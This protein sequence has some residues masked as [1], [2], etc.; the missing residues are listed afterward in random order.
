MHIE[1]GQFSLQKIIDR[2]SKISNGPFGCIAPYKVACTKY[3]HQFVNTTQTTNSISIHLSGRQNYAPNQTVQNQIFITLA[4]ILSDLVISEVISKII[5]DMPSCE[6]N[7]KL[8]SNTQYRS[9]KSEKIVCDSRK[10]PT[11]SGFQMIQSL[12]VADKL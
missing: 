7:L 10:L 12:F 2:S 1:S 11:I 9:C 4:R 8:Q 5:N 3:K 6:L